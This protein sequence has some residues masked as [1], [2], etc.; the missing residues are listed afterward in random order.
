MW[1]PR[2]KWDWLDSKIAANNNLKVDLCHIT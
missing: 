2:S 1:N